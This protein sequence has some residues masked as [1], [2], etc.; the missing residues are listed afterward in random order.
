MDRQR[1]LFV[2]FLALAALIQGAAAE[3]SGVNIGTVLVGHA[4]NAPDPLTGLGAVPYQYYISSTEVT[5]AQYA[6]YMNRVDPHGVN[7]HDI[8]NPDMT[9]VTGFAVVKGGIDFDP[10]APTGTMYAPKPNYGDKPVNYVSFYD[11]ARFAN[12]VMTGNTENGFYTFTDTSTLASQGTHGPDRHNG[13][14]WVAIP[15][16]NEWY[17]AAY[18]KN[19]GATGDYFLYPTSSNTIPTIATAT[20]TGDIANPGQN[21]A[22]YNFGANWDGTGNLGH[23]TTVGSAGLESASPYGT[24]DQGGNMYEWNDA[25]TGSHRVLRGGSL[26]LD[27]E[28]LRST[29]SSF[30]NPNVG[31][32][33]IGFRLS[34]LE[35]ISVVPIP[36]AVW[37]FGSG[38]IGL[39]GLARRRA[40]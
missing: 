24:F 3:A 5:N 4:G 23:F 27:E 32:S 17:K 20:P 7:P 40:A 36:A 26:W 6:S 13:M 19:D 31:G 22:N 21:V 16:Q 1:S 30:Y 38:L 12:W 9:N 28:T 2:I 37:L 33:S 18:H 29:Y 25:V 34:S 35:P 10:G 11:A 8:Y 39:A 14:N 15:S